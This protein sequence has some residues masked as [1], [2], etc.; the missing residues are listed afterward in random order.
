MSP[1]CGLSRGLFGPVA[2]DPV[3]SRLIGRLAADAPTALTAIGEARAIARERAWQLAGQSAPGRDGGLLIVD[4]DATLVTAHSE[5]EQAAPTWKKGYGFHPLTVFA[6]HGADGNGE[7][8]AIMLRPGN[9]GSNTAADHIEAVKAAL[10]QIWC[11][12]VALACE[13]TAWTQLLALTGPARSWE[14]KR[15]RLRLF[16][17][18]GRIVRGGRRLRL[19]LAARWPWARQ[20]TAAMQRLRE[21]A[22][23]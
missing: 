1:C 12:I 18:A 4:V 2:S 13:L 21:L 11:Q 9:A 8:L 15:L 3:I 16:S 14:P 22:P 7:P 23:G 19:R 10:A 5:K 17:A 6:D 20:I